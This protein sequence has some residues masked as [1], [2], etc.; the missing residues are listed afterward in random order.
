M[1][2]ALFIL[3]PLAVPAQDRLKTMPGYEQYQKMNKQITGSVKL[4]TLKASWKN[5]GSAV[6]YTKDG[7]VYR[8]DIAAGKAT[9]VGKAPEED[10]AG[11]ENQVV[12]QR[13]RDTQLNANPAQQ[14]GVQRGRQAVSATSPDGKNKAFYRDY[15]LWI[16]DAKGGKESQISTDGSEKKRIRYGTASWVYG[17]E[18]AQK[19]AMWWSPDSKKVA[20][21]RFDESQVKDYYL[22]TNQ[23]ALQSQV[24]TEP[25]PKPGTANPVVDVFIYDLET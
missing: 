5:G 22:A 15:N 3:L 2:A 19:T 20:Y 14:K 21:Y 17:E 24:D 16:S 7:K 23:A 18:L 6:E 8:Y 1:F 13:Q 10:Q 25:Y 4:A 12:Q 11:E 9:E